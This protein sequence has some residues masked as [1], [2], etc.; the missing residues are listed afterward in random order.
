MDVH[1][2]YIEQR[3]QQAAQ[4]GADHC[5][6]CS[7][8]CVTST[9]TSVYIAYKAYRQTLPDTLYSLHIREGHSKGSVLR[10]RYLWIRKCVYAGRQRG[11]LASQRNK[12]ARD[13]T[14]PFI[15]KSTLLST[16]LCT[17]EPACKVS[18]LSNEN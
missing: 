2:K 13:F 5:A 7:I 8:S 1:R 17:V 14:H 6:L 12:K 15:H 9:L 11:E 10:W 18:V 3:A 4:A 16:E